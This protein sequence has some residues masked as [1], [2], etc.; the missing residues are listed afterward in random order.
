[1]QVG[2]SGIH[3]GDPAS[4]QFFDALGMDYVSCPAEKLPTAKIAAAQAH[5]EAI[6]RKYNYVQ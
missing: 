1:M 5:I 3:A 4:I 2:A 6:N